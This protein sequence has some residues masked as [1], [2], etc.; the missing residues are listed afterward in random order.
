MVGHEAIG[1]VSEVGDAVSS[2]SV[3]DYVVIPDNAA[4]GHLEMV[5]EA[6][7]SF[8]GGTGLGGLQ[9]M[10]F[11]ISDYLCTQVELLIDEM[12]LNMPASPSPT[13]PSS[14]SR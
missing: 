12:Q 3:G 13:T 5:P 14:P 7:D 11:S 4:A 2:L 6:L 1:Y 9:G 8:G 10:C